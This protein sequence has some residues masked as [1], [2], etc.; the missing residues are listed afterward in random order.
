MKVYRKI[1]VAFSNFNNKTV[2]WDKLKK[3]VKV[4]SSTIRRRH[5]GKLNGNS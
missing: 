4:Q 2:C 5:T 3:S 1:L